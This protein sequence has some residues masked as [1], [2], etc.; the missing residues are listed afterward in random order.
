MRKIYSALILKYDKQTYKLINLIEP[1]ITW[2]YINKSMITDLIYKRANYYGNDNLIVPLDNNVVE[3]N[4]GNLNM[5][6]I[7]DVIHELASC[8]KHFNNVVNFLG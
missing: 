8:G 1:Y 3:A 5:V 2:G 7:E 4:L 6:C